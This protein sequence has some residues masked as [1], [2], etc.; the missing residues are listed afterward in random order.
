MGLENPE[1]TAGPGGLPSQGRVENPMHLTGPIQLAAR[2]RWV[3]ATLLWAMHAGSVIP[4]AQAAMLRDADVHLSDPSVRLSD[5]FD[6]VAQDRVIGP[7]PDPGGRIVVESPQ[8]AAIARQFGVDWR[9]TSTADRVVLERP[10][11]AFPREPVLAAL[12]DALLSGGMPANSEIET[13]AFTAPMVPPG[14]SARPDVTEASYEPV[15]GRF[16]ALL[17]ITADG[18]KPF[19]TRLSGH[20]QEMTG[21]QVAT[22]RIAAGEVLT[23]GDIQPARVRAALARSEPAR[24][25]EQAVGMA[26]LHTLNAGSPVLLADLSRPMMMLRG[27][28]VQVLFDQPGLSMTI[29]GVAMEAAALGE[30]VHVANPVSRTV[31]VGLVTGPSQVRTAPG[32]SAV[33]LAPGAPVPQ[34][35]SRLAGR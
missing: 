12:R 29:Q 10:G 7:A 8:L 17:S 32:G 24:L 19:N 18:M 9:P 23:A 4:A 22:R 28:P 6:G 5:L 20:V 16:T 31:V 27:T 25:P 26:V 11:R 2:R 33:P 1:R 35:P 21:L 13:P 14:D 3:V 15:T 34:P 30:P